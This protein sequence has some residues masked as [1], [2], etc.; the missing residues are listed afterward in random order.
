M[1]ILSDLVD[2]HGHSRQPFLIA[3]DRTLGFQ[4]L[5]A[6]DEADLG[7]ISAGD[8]VAVV[9]DFDAGS[10]NT[11]LRLF[12]RGTVVV[13]LTRETRA[14]HPYFFET[15]S[16]DT[17]VEDGTVRRLHPTCADNPLLEELR[18]RRHPGLVL[19]SSGTMGR[20]KAILHD[21]E[22]FLVRF[23]TARPALRTLSFLLFDHIGGIN[24]LLHTLYNGGVV[25]IPQKRTPEGV[26]ADIAAHGVELLPTTP[27]FLRMTL[28][29]GLLD[30]PAPPCL[31]IIT[32]GTERMDQAT[33]DR[34]AAHL[35][36]VELRQTYGMSELG[37]LRVRSKARDSLWITVGGEGVTT[38]VDAGVLKIRAEH[39]MMGYLNAPSPF[40]A[41]GWYNTTDL[42]EVDGEWMK[43]VG[44]ASEV[45]SV[46]GIKVLPGEIER[47]ALLH[48]A[49]ALAQARGVDNPLTGQHIE[50]TCQLRSGATVSVGDL[51]KHMRLHLSEAVRPHRIRIGDVAV[52]H[53]FK[54]Q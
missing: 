4:D 39:R 8:V 15:A 20:P 14:D 47:A 26:F 38:R 1:G 51:R 10:I 12:D 9:G 24:T 41:D 53:R 36:G 27:T 28:M 16:V 21:F 19:F 46:G 54:R 31:R 13:P 11:L 17:V 52:S 29:S 50:L 3:G 6:A 33:L 40:D 34:V 30:A 35:P 37:I 7:G 45:I 32:Y 22:H 2:V 42:V 44:R 25:V 18:A 43:I 5:L 49:V 48:P 23:R